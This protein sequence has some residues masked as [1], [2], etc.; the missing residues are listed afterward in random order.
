MAKVT[1]MGSPVE[2]C[3]E[4]PK[5]GEIAPDFGGVK[6]DLTTAHL[7][8]FKGKKV[9]LN[10]FPSLDTEVCAASVRKFNQMASSLENTVVLCLSKDLPFAQSRF[11]TVEG[12]DNVVPL[13]LF[14]CNCF[15]GKYGVEIMDGPLK[16]LYSRAVVVVDEDG[17]VVYVQLVPEIT[18]EPDYEA[19]L[20]AL[21]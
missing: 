2:L 18:D 13:S 10:I 1:F 21:K 5:T 9:V 11:C 6:G 7:S 3:G 14:R 17:K 19:A 4:L 12:L 8:D 20:A 15:A 16:G